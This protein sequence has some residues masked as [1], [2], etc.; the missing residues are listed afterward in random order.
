MSNNLFLLHCD[1]SI[2]LLSHC[3]KIKIK[4]VPERTKYLLKLF[5][6]S[7]TQKYTSVAR[8]LVT[9]NLNKLNKTNDLTLVTH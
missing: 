5:A 3:R 1:K 9:A 2:K 6:L 8:T 4:L 7:L